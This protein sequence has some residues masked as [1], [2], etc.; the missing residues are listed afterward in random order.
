M[1]VH[2][3]K[4]PYSIAWSK[5]PIEFIFKIANFIPAYITNRTRLNVIVWV[6]TAA[7]SNTFEQAW[8]G[9]EYPNQ[10][11]IFKLNIATILDTKLAYFIPNGINK[12]TIAPQQCKKYYLSYYLSNA[13]NETTPSVDSGKYYVIKGGVSKNN[14]AGDN[15]FAANFFTSKQTL[16]NWHALETIRANESK[17]LFFLCNTTPAQL[18]KTINI[19][20]ADNNTDSDTGVNLQT[21]QIEALNVVCVP[22]DLVASGAQALYTANAWTIPLAKYNVKIAG[23]SATTITE[24]VSFTIDHRPFYDI[25]YIAFRNSTGGLDTQSFV[26]LKEF[27]V[28][29]NSNSVDI[30]QP[31]DMWAILNLQAEKI[32]YNATLARKCKANTGWITIEQLRKLQDLLLSTERYEI[33]NNRLIPINVITKSVSLYKNRDKLYSL[34][35]EWEEATVN[36]NYDHPSL[37]AIDSCPAL[38]WFFPSQEKSNTLTVEWALPPGYDKLEVHYKT[39]A[40]GSFTVLPLTGNTGKTEIILGVP[41][42]GTYTTYEIKARCVCSDV[43]GNTS[44]GAFTSSNI[45]NIEPMLYPIAVNDTVDIVDRNGTIKPLQIN[46]ITFLPT[47]NDI[48]LSGGTIAFDNFYNAAGTATS[49]N[50]KNGATVTL[51]SGVIGYHPS[52]ASLAILA[53][54]EVYYKCKEISIPG[55]AGTPPKSNVATIKVPMKAQIPKVYVKQVLDDVKQ[56][57]VGTGDIEMANIFVAFFKDAGCTQPID[58]TNFGITVSWKLVDDQYTYGVGFTY[59]NVI[60]TGTTA[61][62]GFETLIKANHVTKHGYAITTM[63]YLTYKNNQAAAPGAGNWQPIGW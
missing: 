49:F 45:F 15:F 22:I 27:S 62:S 46:G 19:W 41:A 44:Y 7:N 57:G 40:A 52:P 11:G 18:S 48:P 12:F 36:Q 32:S 47:A 56:L 16:H 58:V 13:N 1:I 24:T 17:W 33:Q 54:D 9:V 2:R 25:S 3:I 53:E 21:I 20:D 26:G 6:E 34:T 29:I 61:C 10:Q 30:V 8:Q 5:N 31:A 37:T 39:L 59:T 51:V 28:E 14:F 63:D 38:D 23:P 60:S 35:I 42:I 4:S 43:P 55:Y 50:S